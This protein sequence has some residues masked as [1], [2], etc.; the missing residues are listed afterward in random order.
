MQ[1]YDVTELAVIQRELRKKIVIEPFLKPLRYILGIDSSYHKKSNAII[2][3]A[4]VYD[5]KKGVVTEYACETGEATFPYIPGY[6]SFREIGTTL[7]AIKMLKH[8]YDVIMVDAQGIAH[9]RGLGFA[10][11]L[12]VLL[13]FPTIGCAKKRLVGE[14]E[15]LSCSKGSYSLLYYRHQV[16]GAV[17]RTKENTKPLFV[18]PG[19]R[20]DIPSSVKVIMETTTRYRLPEPLR[21]AH[22]YSKSEMMKLSN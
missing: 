15:A 13:D 19:H 2:S 18:S 8:H 17:V 6:L 16:C 12:G 1:C 5:L 21:L 10:S 9:P 7:K 22:I 4:L 11:H 3:I 20:V 14:Y